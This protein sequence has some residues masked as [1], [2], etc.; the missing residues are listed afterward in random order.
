[1]QRGERAGCGL[2]EVPQLLQPEP[3]HALLRLQLRH[4]DQVLLEALA[5]G[6]REGVDHEAR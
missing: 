4:D 3:A 6:A 2:Q 1:M 5:D